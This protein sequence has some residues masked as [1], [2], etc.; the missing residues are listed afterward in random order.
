MKFKYILNSENWHCI[1]NTIKT[2]SAYGCSFR[3]PPPQGDVK[4]FFVFFGNEWLRSNKKLLTE[5][6][7]QV[8]TNQVIKHASVVNLPVV[9]KIFEENA[10]LQTNQGGWVHPKNSDSWKELA[11]RIKFVFYRYSTWVFTMSIIDMF[12]NWSVQEKTSSK[13]PEWFLKHPEWG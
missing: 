3:N 6:Q 1:E 7:V 12:S 4:V 9:N 13:I 2:C 11:F 10:C 8:F 5:V